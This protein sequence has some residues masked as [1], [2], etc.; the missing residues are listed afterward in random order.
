MLNERILDEAYNI[1][2]LLDE[3]DVGDSQSEPMESNANVGDNG[4][5]DSGTPPQGEDGGGD[6]LAGGITDDM[7]GDGQD[8]AGGGMDS[9][10]DDPNAAASGIGGSGT[11]STPEIEKVQ[12]AKKIKLL[13][14]YEDLIEVNENLI[15]SCSLISTNLM[16]DKEKNLY[17]FCCRKIK[18]N[19][20]KLIMIV[21][22]K[23]EE[24]S[25]ENLLTLF[26]YCKIVCLNFTEMMD[27]ILN[28]S[29]EINPKFEFKKKRKKS[30]VN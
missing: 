13:K 23:F 11:P 15:K 17:A 8:D 26:F 19:Y 24:M 22:D 21:N 4:G 6:D 14:D 25:Y 20:D 16:T 27:K 28:R 5:A 12:L 30:K 2:S 18:E 3:A 29:K 9:T 10:G 7:D 1:F